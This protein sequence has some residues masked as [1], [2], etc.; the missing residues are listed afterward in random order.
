MTQFEQLELL[1]NQFSNLSDEIKKLIEKEE[2]NVAF[3]KLKYKD[4]LL[5]K[6][7]NA[8]RTVNCNED[9]RKILQLIETKLKEKDQENIKFLIVLKEKVREELKITTKKVKV[10]TAYEKN[11][12]KKTGVLFDSS[13]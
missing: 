11:S 13:E 1:Y 5:K 8:K 9:E 3:D 7:V 12:E 2:Y 10:N 4:K 6:L